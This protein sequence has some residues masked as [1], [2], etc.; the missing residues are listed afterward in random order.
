MDF[1]V[2]SQLVRKVRETL[3]RLEGI[4]HCK[5][6]VVERAGLPLSRQFPLTR[7]WDGRQCGREDCVTCHQEGEE[8]YPCTRRSI[9]YQNIC[10]L[11]NPGGGGK[12]AKLRG[13]RLL[14]FT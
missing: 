10:L 7:L 13:W 8:L 4:I 11:C 6:K 1:S 9:T 14:V 3:A 5:I 2:D 12:V